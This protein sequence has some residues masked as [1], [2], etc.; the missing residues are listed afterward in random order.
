MFLSTSLKL[1]KCL[2]SL[3]L[4]INWFQIAGQN[5]C[6]AANLIHLQFRELS[7][8]IQNFIHLWPVTIS[9]TLSNSSQLY[10]VN[11]NQ[12]SIAFITWWYDELILCFFWNPKLWAHKGKECISFILTSLASIKMSGY[13][14]FSGTSWVE[15]KEP[16]WCFT[17]SS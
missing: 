10:E 17:T 1:A 3:S 8:L 14:G 9:V 11:R 13:Y 16:T 15:F 12:Y 6:Q 7:F 2:L 5:W 4:F